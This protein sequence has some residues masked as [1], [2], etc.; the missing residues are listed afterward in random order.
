FNNHIATVENVTENRSSHLFCCADSTTEGGGDCAVVETVV[1]DSQIHEWLSRSCS[2]PGNL[3][4]IAR[5]VIAVE[6]ESFNTN[7][8]FVT[9][10]GRIRRNGNERAV[11]GDC[12][13]ITTW[14]LQ[15]YSF[16]D[17]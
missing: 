9:Y 14:P 11:A 8:F 4:E 5:S 15:E 12:K 7:S 6:G 3:N 10:S 16:G 17:R 13:S 2:T 1:S